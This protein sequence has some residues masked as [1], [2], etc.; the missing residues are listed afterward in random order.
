MPIKNAPQLRVE[1]TLDRTS[2]VSLDRQI[3]QAIRNAVRSG[4][5]QPGDRLLPIRTLVKHIGVARATIDLAY[6]KLIAEGILESY[7]GCGTFVSTKLPLHNN[8]EHV[9]AAS[10]SSVPVKAK[11][12][13]RHAAVCARAL[14]DLAVQPSMPLAIACTSREASPGKE[15]AD[16]LSRKAQQDLLRLTYSDPQGLPELREAV[17]GLAERLRGVKATP[18]RVII[19]TGSQLGL[20]MSLK[21][22]FSPNDKVWIEDPQYPLLRAA[23]ATQDIRPVYVPV[24]KQGFSLEKALEM[25][26]DARGVFLTPSHQCP[27]GM[28]L[29][30]Q[31]R[32]DILHWARTNGTWIVEDDYDSELRYGGN[33]SYPSLQGMDTS[34]NVVYVGTFSKALFPG[35]RLGYMVVPPELVK[36]FAGMR[37]LIDRQCNEMLQSSV[38]EYIRQGLYEEHLMR[39]RHVFEARRDY[40]IEAVNKNFGDWGEFISTGQGMNVTFAFS[41]PKIDD[42]AVCAECRAQGVEVRSISSFTTSTTMYKG[43]VM[44]FG[45]FRPGQL[46]A[47]ASRI[48]FILR[49]KFAAFGPAGA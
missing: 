2:D 21:I 47:A 11:I 31:R 17:C 40:L 25:D 5:L 3:A 35:L 49:D 36:P 44:G 37:F 15:F 8:F 42:E 27:L 30:I 39:M 20:M 46:L 22:L 1:F 13:G 33:L 38:A 29:G 19:T 6:K 18:D 14:E 45:H 26:P 28:M 10:D 9:P 12:A 41:N 43:L 7:H 23:A 34:G 24:D 32:L 4:Q 48:G 16:I